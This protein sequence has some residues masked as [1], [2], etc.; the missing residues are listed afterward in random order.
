MN[1]LN[2]Y[3]SRGKIKRA[4]ALVNTH[5]I[6]A[7]GQKILMSADAIVELREAA[8][9]VG[10][11]THPETGEIIAVPMRI[12]GFVSFSVPIFALMVFTTHQTPA[13]N[14][15]LQLTNQSYMAGINYANRNGSSEY[16]TKDCVKGYLGAVIAS[17]GIA[18]GTRTMLAPQ[19]RS[20]TGGR[21][22]L[23]QAALNW[24]ACG[25]AGVVNCAMMR[26][27]ELLDGIDVEDETGEW[28]FGKS[29]IAAYQSI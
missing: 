4:Q 20:M 15:L 23:A 21:L 28:K 9:I 3:S 7:N 12:S 24:L 11:T 6:Q 2:F 29:Q 25:S 19:L 13:F 26:Q 10:G 8:S 17:V 5:R 14:A 16:S 18:Y 22:L 27:K 1:P